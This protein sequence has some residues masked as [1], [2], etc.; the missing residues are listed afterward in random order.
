[1]RAIAGLAIA[2]IAIFSSC[3]G[4]G[5]GRDGGPGARRLARRAAPERDDPP[6]VPEPHAAIG[7]RVGDARAVGADRRDTG[8]RDDS[9][10]RCCDGGQRQHGSSVR[11]GC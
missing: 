9:E 10:A 4:D 11:G 3:G 6:P 1:M 5:N 2:S 8:R 7:G